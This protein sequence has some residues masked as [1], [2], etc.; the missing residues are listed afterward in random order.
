MV[1]LG[2]R[3]QPAAGMDGQGYQGSLSGQVLIGSRRVDPRPEQQVAAG[4]FFA[5][6]HPFV[7]VIS[8]DYSAAGSI[9]RRAVG[10]RALG[11]LPGPTARAL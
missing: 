9:G 4:H 8:F 6:E 2:L 7:F 1:L 11:P 3:L 10:G 5:N